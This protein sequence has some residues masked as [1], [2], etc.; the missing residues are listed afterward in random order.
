MC[1]WVCR[2]LS[3]CSRI[4][5][6]THI[7]TWPPICNSCLTACLPLTVPPIVEADSDSNRTR[8]ECACQFVCL[9]RHS[10]KALTTLPQWT[11]FLMVSLM[12]IFFFLLLAALLRKLLSSDAPLGLGHQCVNWMH[13]AQ[14]ALPLRE[15]CTIL[16]SSWSYFWQD[17]ARPQVPFA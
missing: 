8:N 14:W 11:A 13:F 5:K 7:L 1:Q 9:P 3:D 12:E 16:W 2:C 17:T 10:L 6:H 4:H 15:R